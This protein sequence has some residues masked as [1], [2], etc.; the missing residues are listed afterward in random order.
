MRCAEIPGDTLH[1][2]SV[3]PSYSTAD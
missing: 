2:N 3:L 1:P